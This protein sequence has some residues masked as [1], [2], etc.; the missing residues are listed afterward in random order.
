MEIKVLCVSIYASYSTPFSH[1]LLWK[2]SDTPQG[3]KNVDRERLWHMF[4]FH[5]VRGNN[6]YSWLSPGNDSML[7]FIA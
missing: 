2:A 6:S 5:G 1:V 7:Q 3:K 4:V